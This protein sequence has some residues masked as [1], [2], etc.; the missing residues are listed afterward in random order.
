MGWFYSRN[1]VVPSN[2]EHDWEEKAFIVT[3]NRRAQSLWENSIEDEVDIRF[4]LFGGI[5][6][7]EEHTRSTRY[8]APTSAGNPSC[9]CCQYFSEQERRRSYQCSRW[10][11]RPWVVETLNFARPAHS[12]GC[13]KCSIFE[14]IPSSNQ[15]SLPW[16]AWGSG[17][18]GFHLVGTSPSY[19]E[20][21]HNISFLK[22][23][24]NETHPNHPFSFLK[25]QLR[26]GLATNLFAF[27]VERD[28]QLRPL[29]I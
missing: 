22:I 16:R 25:F 24:T 9:G 4:G 21:N 19:T 1:L 8:L 10:C 14:S 23:D 12:T 17:Q 5:R 6:F 11:V 29:F 27:V 20:R 15:K 3:Y 26:F 7:G 18:P 13:R 2:R 28:V